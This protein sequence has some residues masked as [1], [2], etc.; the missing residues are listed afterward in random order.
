MNLN[1]AAI[2]VHP[3][4]ARPGIKRWRSWFYF[5]YRIRRPHFKVEERIR[6]EFETWSADRLPWPV[7]WRML[8]P[9]WP[10]LYLGRG[11]PGRIFLGGYFFTL[12]LGLAL[13][14]ST[15]GNIF[16]GLA[17]SCHACSILNITI[18]HARHL[19]S[20]VFYSFACVVMLMV[21]VYGP[22]EWLIGRVAVPRQFL[23]DVPP[24]N[25]GEVFLY[26]P[27]AYHHS[28]PQN[29]DVVYYRMNRTVFG[30]RY[31]LRTPEVVG[32][33]FAGPH[34]TFT[35]AE[36][37]ILV[38]GRPPAVPLDYVLP[39]D[40]NASIVVPENCHLVITQLPFAGIQFVTVLERD[41]YGKVYWRTQ[42]WSHFGKVR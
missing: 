22:A 28:P 19:S 38:D 17:I 4:R 2:D 42:P 21:L 40:H 14:G 10:Q 8:V 3:P 6:E 36:G 20:R 11:D 32:R 15:L 24:I 13:A 7:F 27:S 35:C 25:A 31:D 18:T 37:R 1:S 9:G 12:L 30:G 29:G 33:V 34:Q 39:S 26:N 41:I 5:I 16:L 23:V